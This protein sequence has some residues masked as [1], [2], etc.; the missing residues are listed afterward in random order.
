MKM[1]ISLLTC[2]FCLCL[3]VSASAQIPQTINY[4]GSLKNVGDGTPVN[5]AVDM[6]FKLCDSLS[7]GT[8]PW[9]ETQSV[10][11]SN[12]IYSVILGNDPTNPLSGLAFDA[13]YY[14]EVA[15]NETTLSPRQQLTAV[16]Y[17]L[18]AASV[19]GIKVNDTGHVAIGTDPG[20]GKLRVSPFIFIEGKTT[21]GNPG[22]SESGLVLSRVDETGVEHRW[23]LDHLPQ[24]S[25]VHK[26]ALTLYEKVGSNASQAR[27]TF[28]AGGNV[29]IGT[30]SPT[31][32][33]TIGGV[34]AKASSISLTSDYST[35]FDYNTGLAFRGTGTKWAT[36]FTGT[37]NMNDDGQIVGIYSEETTPGSFGGDPIAVF[38]NNGNVGIGTATPEYTLDVAGTVRGNFVSS[39][40]V[41]LKENVQLLGNALERVSQ[42][43]GVSFTWKD[44]A[45]GEGPQVGLIAQDVEP[46]FPEVVSTDGDGYKSVAYDKLVAPL[47]EAVKTLKTD[48]DALRAEN[49][50]LR[51][52]NSALH[53]KDDE[54]EQRIMALEQTLNKK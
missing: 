9:T 11:V 27:V 12:G 13:P 23:Y 14:L 24:Y 30:E 25:D 49:E 28:K 31:A 22:I 41:R 21:I 1:K 34:E 17:A 6:T 35:Y 44:T 20:A 18:N 5:G 54:L 8:C 10:A 51:T 39:S 45:K 16:P 50:A 48:N 29:G 43:Q 32:K 26:N 3:I 15:V 19:K 40:D 37:S 38:L 36:R 46:V 4:Q 2:L 33:L 52:E 7:G 47:I 42:L 53:A